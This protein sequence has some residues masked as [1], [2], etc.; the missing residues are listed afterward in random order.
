MMAKYIITLLVLA[1]GFMAYRHGGPAKPRAKD[2]AQDTTK[3]P[4]GVSDRAT[5]INLGADDE[6]VPVHQWVEYA[7]KLRYNGKE[8]PHIYGFR[9]FNAMG[10]L[11]STVYYEH[12][13]IR[14]SKKDFDASHCK[15]L[16]YP[17][18]ATIQL[19]NRTDTLLFFHVLESDEF[20]RTYQEVEYIRMPA[21]YYETNYGTGFTSD[22]DLE[23]NIRQDHD[24][25]IVTFT[26]TEIPFKLCQSCESTPTKVSFL[27]EDEGRIYFI[28]KDCWLELLNEEDRR[29]VQDLRR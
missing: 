21:I 25:Y 24:R 23:F 16:P 22:E 18:D 12:M 6:P 15:V 17:G 9:Y 19:S 8:Y 7:G 26:G 13:D 10:K 5:L 1:L 20:K 2:S 14:N 29:K 28:E 27:N 3:R 4:P 11:L